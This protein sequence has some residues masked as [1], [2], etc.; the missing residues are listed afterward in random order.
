MDERFSAP[1]EIVWF[2]PNINDKENV[3]NLQYL[4]NYLK[5]ITIHTCV[6]QDEAVEKVKTTLKNRRL[7]VISCGS[8]GQEFCKQI[9]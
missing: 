7:L 2:D 4:K 9:H 6:N 3:Y 5:T 8:K 1:I